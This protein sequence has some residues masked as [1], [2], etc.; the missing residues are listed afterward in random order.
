MTN[1]WSASKAKIAEAS[2]CFHI[3]WNPNDNIAWNTEQSMRQAHEAACE[4]ES[5]STL[6]KQST[7]DKRERFVS[8]NAENL[9]KTKGNTDAHAEG[10][11][12]Y[13]DSQEHPQH[14]AR[15]HFDSSL[16]LELF[17]G[18]R[19]PSQPVTKSTNWICF[20]LFSF[21][22]PGPRGGYN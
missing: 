9:S 12:V 11:H 3:P 15:A 4:R 1:T 17:R 21:H 7:R 20:F 6:S 14:T 5:G 19:V 10:K 22:R 2:R 13:C 18:R 16:S 8:R